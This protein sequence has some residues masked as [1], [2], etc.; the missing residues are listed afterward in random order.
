MKVLLAIPKREQDGLGN[1]ILH[2]IAER[3]GHPAALQV[4]RAGN[5][6][7]AKAL[8]DETFDLVVAHLDLPK[9]AGARVVEGALLGM[10]VLRHY[11]FEKGNKSP[12]LLVTRATSGGMLEEAAA[13]GKCC[14]VPQIADMDPLLSEAITKLLPQQA[15]SPHANRKFAEVEI[16]LLEGASSWRI[17]KRSPSGNEFYNDRL[18]IDLS[19]LDDVMRRHADIASSGYPRWQRELKEMG[20]ALVA[21]LFA[22]HRF[23]HYFGRTV[24]DVGGLDNVQIR[25]VVDEK[26][27]SLGWEALCSQDFLGDEPEGAPF[28]MLKSPIMRNL[29]TNEGFYPKLAEWR[30]GGEL[31]CLIIDASFCAFVPRMG[32]FPELE[33]VAAEC[34][35]LE[36]IIEGHRKECFDQNRPALFHAPVRL[37]PATAPKD[38]PFHLHV[39]ETLRNG[40][41][42]HIVHFGGHAYY[43]ERRGYGWICF[44]GAPVD[45]IELE[46]FGNWLRNAGFVYLSSCREPGDRSVYALARHSIP[47][48]LGFRWDMDDHKAMKHAESFYQELICRSTSFETASVTARRSLYR[49]YETD[50]AWAAPLLVT[51]PDPHPERFMRPK[52]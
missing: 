11:R 15:N 49:H 18:D 4:E 31:N 12:F 37:S 50:R 33:N 5:A 51:Q 29:R 20:K 45:V 32:Y 21:R 22:D 23:K 40:T 2:L 39:R 9:N 13:L 7:D 43:D 24:S 38:K 48:I 17:S 3:A 52:P 16:H 10:G 8:A 34:D 6:A 47:A 41:M 36:A 30:K 44:P 27:Q 46:R 35:T 28:W 42:W 26:Y 1:L 14:V 25:F 19:N